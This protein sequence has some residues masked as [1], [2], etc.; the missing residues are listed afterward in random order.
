MIHSLLILFLCSLIITSTSQA[1]WIED[2]SRRQE[3][4]VHG[5]GALIVNDGVLWFW[6]ETKHFQYSTDYGTTWQDPGDEITGANPHVTHMSG[7]G[8]RVYAA[9]NFGTGTGVPIYSSDMGVTWL[10]DT[11]GAPGNSQ[12]GRPTVGTTYAWGGKWIYVKWGGP[13]AHSFKTF[14]GSYEFNTFV[15]EGANRPSSVVAKGDT[16]FLSGAKVYYTTDGGQTF[17]TP[18]NNGYSG[19]GAQLSADGSR[20]YMAAYEGWMKPPHIFYSDDNA[21]NWTKGPEIPYPNLY[22]IRGNNMEIA[23]NLEKFNSPPNVKFSSDG[24]ATFVSDTLGLPTYYAPGVTGFAYTPDGTLWVSPAHQKLFKRKF[25]EGTGSTPTVTEAPSMISPEHDAMMNIVQFT[26]H[27]VANALTYHLQVARDEEFADIEVDREGITDTLFEPSF[28]APGTYYWRVQGIRDEQSG[29][30]S[31]ARRFFIE[32][33]GVGEELMRA[34]TVSPNPVQASFRLL[35]V[36]PSVA[37]LTIL[38]ALGRQVSMID[39]PQGAIGVGHLES[40]SYM[41]KV[42]RLDGSFEMVRLIVSH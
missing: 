3:M 18:A 31:V 16:L 29:P 32:S 1:Q 28:L 41:L 24:G 37:S 6:N 35:G 40:G 8:N 42:H 20:L 36:D 23:L 30:W 13:L 34:L 14:N 2:E 27:R 26:W 15:N 19:Y 10:P 38:D 4:S 39:H 21:E 25:D 33:L 9:L 17:V 7:S 22:F 11:L 12:T 5:N